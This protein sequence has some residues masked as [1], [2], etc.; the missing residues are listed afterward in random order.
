M[1]FA[2]Q[3]REVFLRGERDELWYRRKEPVPFLK[4]LSDLK[5]VRCEFGIP[6]TIHTHLTG[7]YLFSKLSKLLEDQTIQLV[8]YCFRRGLWYVI[9]QRDDIEK[10]SSMTKAPDE[11]QDNEKRHPLLYLVIRHAKAFGE[12]TKLAEAKDGYIFRR[13]GF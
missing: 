5:K 6:I 1:D 9:G 2:E 11:A 7:I 4:P 8:A 3:V 13:I 12:V 10:S